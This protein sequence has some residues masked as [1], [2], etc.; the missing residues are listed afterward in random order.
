[1]NHD[2]DG[3]LKGRGGVWIESEVL[4]A[5]VAIEDENA[6]VVAKLGGELRG[7]GAL[8]DSM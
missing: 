5:N 4:L 8:P 2:T 3:L 1:M 7:Q 6:W